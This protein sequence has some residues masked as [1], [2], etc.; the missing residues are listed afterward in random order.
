M[1]FPGVSS[2]FYLGKGELSGVCKKEGEGE[3]IWTAW[4][5]TGASIF[6]SL[7]NQPSPGFRTQLQML[8]FWFKGVR[9]ASTGYVVCF[10]P[11]ALPRKVCL[12]DF[13]DVSQHGCTLL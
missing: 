9:W 8:E 2:G 11:N 13:F 3:G 6:R 7:K 12:S 4:W 10:V 5:G 1:P